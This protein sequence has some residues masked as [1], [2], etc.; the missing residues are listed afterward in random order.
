MTVSPTY[1]PDL[2]HAALDLLIDRESGIW[3][4]TNGEPITWLDLAVRAAKRAEV[5]CS[6][7][8][9]CGSEQLRLA[10]ARPRYS[11]LS[12]RRAYGM[13]CLDDALDRYCRLVALH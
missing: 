2:V 7:L 10:A 1:V 13:P 12:S 3:H 9:A 8:H 6:S 4:L 11:A 5:D